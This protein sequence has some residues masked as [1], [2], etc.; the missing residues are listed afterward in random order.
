MSVNNNSNQVNN[1]MGNNSQNKNNNPFDQFFLDNNV[2]VNN[3]SNQFNN[4][5]NNMTD[6]TGIR[7][8]SIAVTSLKTPW[9]I[10]EVITPLKT[11]SAVCT[12][13]ICKLLSTYQRID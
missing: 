13:G 10:E 2:N 7:I 5:G 4:I 11:A 3:N 1:N 8:G 12:I 6:S 9:S